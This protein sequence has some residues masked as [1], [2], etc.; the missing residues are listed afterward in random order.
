MNG[1]PAVNLST[2]VHGDYHT[3]YDEWT[4]INPEGTAAVLG[5]AA[6]LVDYLASAG[7]PENSPV[8]RSRGMAFPGKGF[9]SGRSP[10]I[11]AAAR[12]LRSSASSKAALRHKPGSKPGTGW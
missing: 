1:I 7:R 11:P 2:G 12:G 10:I 6:A 3:P 4:K 8:T 5:A 9:I